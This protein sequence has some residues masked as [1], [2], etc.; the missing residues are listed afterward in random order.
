MRTMYDSVN[1]TSPPAGAQLYAGYIDITNEGLDSY[2]GLVARFPNAIVI[3][4]ATKSTTNA[5]TI[6]DV[7]NGDATPA[8][9]VQ[10][11]V[12]RR[13]AGATPTVY[14][15]TSAW[16]GIQQDFINAN[17]AQPPYWVANYNNEATVPAG[18]V[19]HQYVDTGGYDISAVV[20]YWPGVDPPPATVTETNMNA[21]DPT[22]GGFWVYFPSDGHI[23]AYGGAPY[24]GAPN[25]HVGEWALLGT[26]SGFCAQNNVAAGGWGY[27]ITTTLS[28]PNANGT[29]CNNYFFPRN[30]AE[31]PAG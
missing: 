1:A 26:P 19:A 17:V 30:N 9:A 6:L 8:E 15:S 14:C 18:A 3:P 22:S 25:N 13:A 16:S 5:G 11:V 24:L 27:N 7:E 28:T 21:T 31:N 10:W 2:S 4:I 23:E 20:D 12:M 29:W